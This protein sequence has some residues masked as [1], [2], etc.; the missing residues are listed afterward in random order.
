M[1]EKEFATVTAAIRAPKANNRPCG[2][3]LRI[4]GRHVIIRDCT[5]NGFEYGAANPDYGYLSA[6]TVQRMSSGYILG[7]R[8]T[9]SNDRLIDFDPAPTVTWARGSSTATISTRRG[10]AQAR[11]GACREWPD[12]SERDLQLL[13][14]YR[15]ERPGKRS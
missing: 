8:M 1:G 7:C 12:A 14:Q 4:H 5:F 2:H 3:W 9:G 13:A 15:C 11:G 10:L 6:V